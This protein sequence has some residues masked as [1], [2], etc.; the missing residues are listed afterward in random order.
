MA[1]PAPPAETT[2]ASMSPFLGS[3]AAAPIFESLGGCG[4]SSVVPD[5]CRSS[6]CFNATKRATSFLDMTELMEDALGASQFLIPEDS[7]LPTAGDCAPSPS[8]P[9][10]AAPSP[11]APTAGRHLASRGCVPASA[12]T[13]A[14]AMHSSVGVPTFLVDVVQGAVFGPA[15]EEE[16]PSAACV[17]ERAL[18]CLELVEKPSVPHSQPCSPCP[19]G[20]E[21][22]SAG[23]GGDG[24]ATD[25]QQRCS[26]EGGSEG[27]CQQQG[28]GSLVPSPAASHG[29]APIAPSVAGEVESSAAGERDAQALGGSCCPQQPAAEEEQVEA[30]AAPPARTFHHK[31]GGPCDHCGATESPQWRRGPPAKPMLC[32]AW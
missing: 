13:T 23:S 30:A 15:G 16:F 18:R 9:A 28:P 22:C 24:A 7:C 17:F 14:L 12:S 5:L 11:S 4:P 27:S 10:T 2:P 21:R 32:N 6:S 20:H 25:V 8:R 1:P 29:S 31:T 19:P 26:S 3:A